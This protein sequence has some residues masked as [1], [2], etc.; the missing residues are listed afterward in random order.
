MHELAITESILEIAQ[1][2]GK[3][4]GATRISDIHLVIGQLS[5]VIDDSVRFYWDMISEGTIA[6]GAHLHFRRIPA[7][8]SCLDCEEGYKPEGEDFACPQCGSAH[9][10]LTAGSEFRVEAIEV[11]TPDQD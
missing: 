6:E 4:A 11:D 8:F 3:Q 1:R 7:E 10:K 9:V 5:S 2:H